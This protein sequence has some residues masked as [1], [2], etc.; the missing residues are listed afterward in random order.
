MGLRR[1][2]AIAGGV[3]PMLRARLWTLWWRWWGRRAS[4]RRMA[5]IWIRC[6]REGHAHAYE[7]VDLRRCVRCGRGEKLVKGR[8]LPV[9]SQ[10]DGSA[11]P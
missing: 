1:E 5:R 4:E 2:Y 9:Y 6:R 10:V 11:N 3:Y 8:W 7:R